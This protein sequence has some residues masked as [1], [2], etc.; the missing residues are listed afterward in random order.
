M[1]E[2]L[3]MLKVDS[4]KLRF[5]GK[6]IRKNPPEKYVSVDLPAPKVTSQTDD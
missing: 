3:D 6:D 1:T 5:S 4:R 2:L